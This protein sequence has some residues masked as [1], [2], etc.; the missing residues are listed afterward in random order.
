MVDEGD[1]DGISLILLSRTAYEKGEIA[2]A[3]GYLREVVHVMGRTHH[4]S[5]Q[6]LKS[7]SDIAYENGRFEVAINTS[8]DLL[9]CQIIT[10][11]VNNTETTKTISSIRALCASSGNEAMADEIDVMVKTAATFEK[12]G[13]KMKGLRTNKQEVSAEESFQDKVLKFIV[14]RLSEMF[15]GKDDKLSFTLMLGT[16]TGIFIASQLILLLLSMTS[17]HEGGRE[18]LS[19]GT[20]YVTADAKK[21]MELRS[22]TELEI[23]S[24]E[25]KASNL[26]FKVFG[27]SWRDVGPLMTSSIF[28]KEHW[29][30]E[31]PQGLQ[32]DGVIYYRM[33][34]PELAIVHQMTDV[35]GTANGYFKERGNYPKNIKQISARSFRFLNPFTKEMDFP[36]IRS[37]YLKDPQGPDTA[38]F[39][40][41]LTNGAHWPG[42]LDFY[43]GAIECCRVLYESTTTNQNFVAHGCDRNGALIRD[44][45]GQV[46]LLKSNAGEIEVKEQE[47]AATDLRP[48][49]IWVLRAPPEM[50]S[51]YT[52]F[53]KYRFIILYG[54]TTLL[55]VVLNFFLRNTD[56][57]SPALL[58]L[59]ISTMVLSASAI[60][61]YA[62]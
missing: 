44:S 41:A 61:A 21:R 8:L 59:A 15:K 18:L 56:G 47:I 12:E 11:G 53:L 54:T 26:S 6:A 29:V 28:E 4:I 5:H 45:R 52:P 17:S 1:E 39:F 57:R 40:N 16:I 38:A 9:D 35:V 10:Y 48:P 20:E 22:A 60:G 14:G 49:T 30:V 43:P 3:E 7:L 31:V 19:K 46:L 32:V 51:T 62:P 23:K 2:K 24:G 37:V 55:M 34:A 42:E 58:M 13:R 27:H 36:T 25:K 33:D 50:V